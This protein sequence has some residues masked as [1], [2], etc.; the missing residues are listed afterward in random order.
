MKNFIILAILATFFVS[1]SSTYKRTV[2]KMNDVS[3]KPSWAN[4][5]KTVWMDD[6]KHYAVGYVE[7]EDGANMN[8]LF[9]MAE[10]NARTELT[11]TLSNE[12]VATSENSNTG[13]HSQDFSSVSKE[14]SSVWNQGITPEK[15][16]YEKVRYTYVD[17]DSKEIKVLVYAL[18][19]V[20]EKTYNELKTLSKNEKFSQKNKE[21]RDVASE[22]VSE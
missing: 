18:V 17:E 14:Y 3:S 21:V 19:S 5:E 15:R 12:V 22:V 16:Y 11:K 6:G 8:A 2:Y 4:L 10:N 9:K 7:A 1:C 13:T 20:S